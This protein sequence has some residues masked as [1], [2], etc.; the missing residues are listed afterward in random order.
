M[1]VER[2][3]RIVGGGPEAG[4]GVQVAFATSDMRHVDQHFGSAQGL[5]RYAVDP[6]RIRLLEVLQFVE[7]GREAGTAEPGSG[8][9]EGGEPPN[10]SAPTKGAAA[11]ADHASLGC[12][13]GSAFGVSDRYEDKLAAKLEAL[14]GCS[15]MFCLAVGASAVR[16]LLAQDIQPIK[17]RP[18]TS[19][20]ELLADLQDQLKDE[21]P[22][23]LAKAVRRRDGSDP[24]RFDAMDS[25]GW[26]E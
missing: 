10:G 14:R 22:A 23:W 18:G 4:N 20:R 2:R 12:D 13:A 8:G 5:A 21:P 9:V 24:A 17:V 1:G 11:P 6:R 25:E 19:I 15:A 3:M 7:P 16:Q 26:N